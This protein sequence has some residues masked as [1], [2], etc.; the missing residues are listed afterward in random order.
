MGNNSDKNKSNNVNKYGNQIVNIDE[1]LSAKR[2]ELEHFNAQSN[3]TLEQAD[4][5]VESEA[6]K[7]EYARLTNEAKTRFEMASMNGR[8][9][10]IKE[11]HSDLGKFLGA[12]KE[13]AIEEQARLVDESNSKLIESSKPR[14]ELNSLPAIDFNSYSFSEVSEAA[15][16]ES[17]KQDKPL[18]E[19]KSNS[20][21]QGLV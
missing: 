6:K 13:S 9:D 11:F 21:Y 5:F 7:A 19:S 15:Q 16:L 12:V 10:G 18:L 1:L 17:S 14:E 2:T 20:K 4:K 8:I 3:Q